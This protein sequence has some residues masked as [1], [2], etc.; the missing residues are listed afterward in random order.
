A[1]AV[2]AAF[3]RRI[4]SV[5]IYALVLHIPFS[6]FG[7]SLFLQDDTSTFS[8]ARGINLG[9]AEVLLLIGYAV[10]FGRVVVARTEPPPPLPW[11]DGL[12]ALFLFAQAVSMAQAPDKA[13]AVFDIVYNVKLALLYFFLSRKVRRA[14]LRGIIVAL[15][16]GILLESSLAIF[17]E[18]LT[19]NIGIGR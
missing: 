19:G 2:L 11:V 14:H 8:F 17:Y 13:K 7:K 5:L 16:L 6:L 12:M 9:G 18:R 1:L 4:D 15:L 10:W 3:V